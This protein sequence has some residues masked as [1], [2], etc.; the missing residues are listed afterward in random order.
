TGQPGI[1][2]NKTEPQGINVMQRFKLALFVP[3]LM[4]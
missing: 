1:T 4:C 2:I 3:P